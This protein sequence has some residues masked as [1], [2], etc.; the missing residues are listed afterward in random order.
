MTQSFSSFHNARLEPV[1][2][3]QPACNMLVANRANRG[4][5]H[6]KSKPSSPGV[7]A[8]LKHVRWPAILG[9][10]GIK[11]E[12]SQ[13]SALQDFKEPPCKRAKPEPDF[14]NPPDK[15]ILCNEQEATYATPMS[16]VF[17][18]MWCFNSVTRHENSKHLLKTYHFALCKQCSSSRIDN[19]TASKLEK[20]SAGDISLPI[21]DRDSQKLLHNG[22]QLMTHHVLKK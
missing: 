10:G 21:C 8:M 14:Y 15:C 16:N 2:E 1:T 9:T 13:D 17:G 5:K 19:N 18:G 7:Q 22:C 20:V 6:T 11:A 3:H 4:R 12:E